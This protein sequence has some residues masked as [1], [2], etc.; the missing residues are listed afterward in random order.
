VHNF[1]P[2]WRDL[3][4][5][6]IYKEPKGGKSRQN[7]CGQGQNMIW[8]LIKFLFGLGVLGAI[9]LVGYAYLGPIFMPADFAA[10]TVDISQPVT[11]EGN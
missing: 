3:L 11:L 10:P 8:R 1:F 9:G 2:Q 6:A 4:R 7:V 5:I